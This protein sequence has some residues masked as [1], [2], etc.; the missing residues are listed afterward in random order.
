M[1]LV[2]YV[3]LGSLSGIL[4]LW[5][6]LENTVLDRFVRYTI[7]PYAGEWLAGSSGWVGGRVSTET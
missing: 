5:F 1:Q 3:V 6:L 4:V 2:V 7:T